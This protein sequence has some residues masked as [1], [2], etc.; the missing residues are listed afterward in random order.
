MKI[1][2]GLRF[3][4]FPT[5]S[6]DG[7]RIYFS[8]TEEDGPQGLWWIP[9]AGGEPAKV[10]AFDDPERTVFS[11]GFGLSSERLYLALSEYESDI[12]VTD[13]N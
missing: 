8:A 10:M 3:P 6:P 1:G 12:W 13:L 5:F 11:A 2:A 7:S 4:N 9:S